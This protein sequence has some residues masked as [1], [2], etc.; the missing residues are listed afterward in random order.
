M[1]STFKSDGEHP[2]KCNAVLL[3]I[4]SYN[5]NLRPYNDSKGEGGQAT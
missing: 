3:N 1:K 2:S 4:L 5:T